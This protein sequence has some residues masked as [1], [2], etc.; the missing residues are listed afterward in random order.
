VIDDAHIAYR[1]S[2]RE[3]VMGSFRMD[4]LRARRILGG[5]SITRLAS[6]SNTSDLQI[7]RLEDVS[8]NGSGVAGVCDATSAARIVNALGPPV[9]L[10]SNSQLSPTVFTTATSHTF[11]TGDS[12]T[13]AGVV[14]ANADPNGTRTVTRIDGTSFSVPVNCTSAGGTGGTATLLPASVTQVAL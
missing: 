4:G 14:G 2:E 12:V 7:R 1:R 9:A 3:D 5:L 6:L 11:Q 10:T 13:I 8:F